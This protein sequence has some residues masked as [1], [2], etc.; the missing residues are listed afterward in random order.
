[1]R[2]EPRTLSGTGGE[3][4]APKG[5]EVELHT[6]ADRN[7]ETAE[8]E[9]VHGGDRRPATSGPSKGGVTRLA[10]SVQ[11]R[12]DLGGRVVVEDNG[13]YRFR[14]LDRKGRAAAEGPP[15][16][17][18]AEPDLPPEARITS[19]DREL[20]VDAGAM[21]R[22]EWQA[23]DDVGLSEVA[24]VVTPPSGQERRRVLRAAA[25]VRRDAGTFDLELAPGEARGGRG[26][27]LPARGGGRGPGLRPEDRRLRHA[28]REDLL[29]GGAP[30]AGAR[31]GEAAVRGD[32]D[33]P[34][35]PARD[36]LRRAAH[37][38]RPAHR[39]EPA[40]RAHPAAAR[41]DARDRARAAPRPGRAEADRDRARERG[42]AAPVRGAARHRRAPADRAGLPDP[43][44]PGRYAAPER[45]RARRAARRR[46]GE[47]DPL[48][49]AAPRQA[50]GGGPR[51]ARE[52]P[53]QAAHRAR[54]PAREVQGRAE[55]GRE[56]GA[57]RAHLPD[58]G[59]REG[60]AR[61][62]E[63]GGAR[64][65]RRAHER[66][67]ARRAVEVAGPHRRAR[68]RRE[69]P[70]EGGRRGRDA[71]AR[72]AGLA[73]RQDGRRDAAHGRDAGREGARPHEG[74]ARLQGGA[75]AGQGGAGGG[76]PGH[77]GRPEEV[78]GRA[79]AEAEERRAE[80][81]GAREARRQR[82]GATSRRRSP[83]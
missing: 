33:A 18:V 83:A 53:R 39:R 37:H 63:R 1:M 31:E 25:D 42:R 75:R 60:A 13:S 80:G 2:R 81:E 79:R 77:R 4:R 76:G 67:G 45:R 12:R 58:E 52:G 62:D 11:N 70:R 14:F 10:L 26:A 78:P 72:P 49:R 57:A 61:Q 46:A 28:P 23:E 43:H 17:I 51:A 24:L 3:I 7:V 16:P 32:G 30:P 9:V 69:A 73:A 65:Q 71:R 5:T 56:E 47:G 34:R 29:G 20:E 50:A 38:P 15:I 64:L 54:R 41:A 19:P 22:I 55:R 35:R 40:R 36:A 6:R 74:D 8:L 59:P 66:G 21:V 27:L 82:R 44:P 68:R 48:P